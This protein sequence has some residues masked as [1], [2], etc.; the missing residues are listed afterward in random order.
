[1]EQDTASCS[2]QGCD[3]LVETFVVNN[4]V[5]HKCI[6]CRKVLKKGEK[7]CGCILHNVMHVHCRGDDPN[8]SEDSDSN[9]NHLIIPLDNQH[10]EV[11]EFGLNFNNSIREN[12][13]T[14]NNHRVSK[15]LI[16]GDVISIS[17]TFI[18]IHNNTLTNIYTFNRISIKY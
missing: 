16:L 3:K 10:S 2:V 17:L 12:S 18:N 9:N 5:S 7:A 11:I 15:P 6:G 13:I 14:L 8:N 1:M 4:S